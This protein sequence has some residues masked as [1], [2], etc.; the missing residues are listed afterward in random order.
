MSKYSTEVRFICETA[1]GLI[2]SKGYN[3]IESIIDK[4]VNSIFESDIPF[5]D[6]DYGIKLEKK[7]LRHYYTREIGFETVGLWKLQLNTTMKEIMPYYNKLYKTELYKYDPL[8]DFDYTIKTDGNDVRTDDLTKS[9]TGTQENKLTNNLKR[10][11]TGTQEVKTGDKN[12]N[13]FSDTPQGGLDDVESGT[14]LTNATI[15]NS[16][17]SST[18]TDDLVQADT[19]T[20]DTVRTDN[21]TEKNT[22]TVGNIIDRTERRYG[23]QGSKS[24]AEM[25]IQERESFLNI[26]MQ[27]IEELNDLFMLVW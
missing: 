8:S 24:Y 21:L 27:V 13:K 26:D 14:Y 18:R 17:G 19:G 5:F 9:N 2:E 7:I 6:N 23:K 12:V 16:E 25:I 15:D 4:A 11:N 10:A 3:D 20:A 1:V 22:G